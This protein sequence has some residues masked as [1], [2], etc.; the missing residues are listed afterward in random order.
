ML[1]H[2][3]IIG[4]GGFIGSV[5]RYFVSLLNLSVNFLSIPVGTL[6]VNVVG[7][8]V[9]G[10]IIGVAEKSTILTTEWRLFLMVGLC[11]GFTTFSSFAGENLVL[12]HN[13]QIFSLFLYTGLSIFMGF[14]AVWAGY[15]ATNLF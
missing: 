7:S 5:A 8:F 4:F 10:F 14:L 15:S 11:G 12:M 13:G 2:I 9:I 1:K 6:L 3:L